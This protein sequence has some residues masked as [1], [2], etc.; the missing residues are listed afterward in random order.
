MS[1]LTLDIRS[2]F[3]FSIFIHDF[4][5]TIEIFGSKATFNSLWAQSLQPFSD[6]FESWTVLRVHREKPVLLRYRWSTQGVSF[7]DRVVVGPILK[8][9]VK[10]MGRQR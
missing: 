9:R 3:S 10:P 5:L 1:C 4:V 6:N 7:Y 8:L 2:Q